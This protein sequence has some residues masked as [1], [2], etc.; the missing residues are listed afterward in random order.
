MQWK[1]LELELASDTLDSELKKNVIELGHSLS[2]LFSAGFKPGFR[3]T[4][5]ERQP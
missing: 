2:I 3:G 5:K 1:D 4:V